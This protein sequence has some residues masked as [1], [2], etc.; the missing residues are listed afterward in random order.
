MMT[1]S[2]LRSSTRASNLSMPG[3]SRFFADSPPSTINSRLDPQGRGLT[4][5]GRWPG[6]PPALK[7]K[8]WA[9]GGTGSKRSPFYFD[10]ALAA[11]IKHVRLVEGVMDAA[12]A[13][14]AG[15]SSVVACVAASL[16]KE[17]GATLA[18]YG[19][20][21]VTIC[22][23]PDSAGENG[24]PSCIRTMEP[25]NIDIFVAPKLPDGLDPDEFIIQWGIEAWHDHCQRADQAYRWMAEQ[26]VRLPAGGVWTDLLITKAWR[27]A[28]AFSRS[29]IADHRK[30]DLERFFWPTIVHVSGVSSNVRCSLRRRLSR[31]TVE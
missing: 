6:A 15:D 3:R 27:A 9:L 26:V 16:S 4:I 23:D 31:L 10:R 7:P 17:Q 28:E 24:T 12:V 20:E 5:Y 11:G 30:P 21:A 22:L 19:V 29:V 25:N 13:R 18:R 8:T 2:T 14:A 1:V